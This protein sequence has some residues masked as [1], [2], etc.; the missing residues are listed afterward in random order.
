MGWGSWLL[1]AKAFG[2]QTEGL[3]IAEERV[4]FAH[5][6]G[7]KV[8]APTDIETSSYH[9]INA[10]QV[11]EHVSDPVGVL[12]SCYQWLKPGG[13]LRVAVPDGVDIE[14][15]IQTG[16]WKVA[17]MPSIPLEH[18]NVFTHESLSYLANQ[19]HFKMVHPPLVLPM[20]GLSISEAKHWVSTLLLDLAT[21]ARMVKRT[22]IWL[23]K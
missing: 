12:A 23:Q 21:R 22:I 6:N 13:F 2:M 14:K 7:L 1:M 18:I 9:F 10:E 15:R 11:L 16:S 8:V 17:E 3:E 20:L 4:Q 5:T 19:Q